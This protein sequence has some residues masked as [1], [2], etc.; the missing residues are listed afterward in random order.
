MAWFHGE[1]G[2]GGQPAGGLDLRGGE[3]C[4]CI[5]I[6]ESFIHAGIHTAGAFRDVVSVMHGAA[7]GDEGIIRECAYVLANPWAS[8]AAPAGSGR[9]GSSRGGATASSSLPSSASPSSGLSA[10]TARALVEQGVVAG[11]V[12]LLSASTP[13]KILKVSDSM[14]SGWGA[15]E[16]A[17]EGRGQ[18]WLP[19]FSPS[20][21][22]P[23]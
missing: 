11:L 7:A 21:I 13:P 17:G 1:G 18:I 8:P 20:P 10:E 4:S 9:L 5:A 6:P 14:P 23:D 12:G 22:C 2:R 3:G 19:P 15:G 16:R